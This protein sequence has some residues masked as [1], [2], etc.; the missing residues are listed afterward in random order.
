MEALFADVAWTVF[1]LEQF[2]LWLLCFWSLY[3]VL[4]WC[5]HCTKKRLSWTGKY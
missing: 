4:L 5:G 3:A 2:A 1:R